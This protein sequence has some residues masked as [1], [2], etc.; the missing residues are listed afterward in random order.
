MQEM[1][2]YSSSKLLADIKISLKTL[3]VVQLE[4]CSSSIHMVNS[5][6]RLARFNRSEFRSMLAL[7]IALLNYVVVIV[8]QPSAVLCEAEVTEWVQRRQS[9]DFYSLRI[10]NSSGLHQ[11][12][13]STDATY[14]VDERQCVNDQQL[15]LKGN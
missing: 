6:A 14:L 5:I 1:Q 7:M 15:L 4:S 3:C 8:L 11:K 10:Y 2:Q 9:G 13:D 12:C